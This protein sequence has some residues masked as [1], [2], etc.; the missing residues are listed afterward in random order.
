LLFLL[1]PLPVQLVQLLG[2]LRVVEVDHLLRVIPLLLKPLPKLEPRVL[3]RVLNATFL[4]LVVVCS[5]TI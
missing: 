5:K 2:L 1:P 4:A 3:Q